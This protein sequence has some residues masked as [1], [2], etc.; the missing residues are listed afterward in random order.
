VLSKM[1]SARL[2]LGLFLGCLTLVSANTQY[3]Q[4]GD[5]HQL[6]L[7]APHDDYPGAL[8][9]DSQASSCPQAPPLHPNQHASFLGELNQIYS[10]NKF[11]LDAVE[12]LSG[13]VQIPS[14]SYDGMLPVGE[15][16]RW[17]IFG[18]LHEYFKSTFPLV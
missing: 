4:A 13:A 7:L 16:T 3:L 10:T 2:F 15:D 5:A 8:E 6:P 18:K 9:S 17:Q 11:K 14:E 1:P 12:A